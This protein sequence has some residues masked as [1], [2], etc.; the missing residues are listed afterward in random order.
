[1]KQS[2]T[3]VVTLEQVN[4]GAVG[5][6]FQDEFKKILNNLADENTSWKTQ[7]EITIKLKV[8]L[9]SE[10]RD[11]ATTLIEVMSKVAPPKP[12]ES[13]VHLDYDGSNIQAFAREEVKQPE[14]TNITDI[15]KGVINE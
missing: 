7:R 6:L 3:E 14:L 2:F 15:K 9:N 10:E 8:K 12:N 4:N 5:E 11:T 1:M 13:I